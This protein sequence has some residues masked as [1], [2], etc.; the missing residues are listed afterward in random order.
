MSR[1][2]IAVVLVVAPMLTLADDAEDRLLSAELLEVSSGDFEKAR[3]AFQ[4]I[5]SDEKASEAVPWKAQLGLS[6]CQRKL[7]QLEAA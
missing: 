7:G 1:I 5:A 2:G 6:R 3:A 4:L